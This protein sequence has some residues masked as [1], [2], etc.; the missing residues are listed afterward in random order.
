VDKN[1]CATLENAMGVRWT[2]STIPLVPW[3]NCARCP[4]YGSL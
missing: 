3:Q 4:V 2:R 1:T